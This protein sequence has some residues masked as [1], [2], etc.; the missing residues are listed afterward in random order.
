MTKFYMQMLGTVHVLKI[1]LQYALT[2]LINNDITVDRIF[3]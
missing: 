1:E 3:L 2:V